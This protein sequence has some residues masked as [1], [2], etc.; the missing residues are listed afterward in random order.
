MR[1]GLPVRT[2]NLQKTFNYSKEY[3]IMKKKFDC[4]TCHSMLHEI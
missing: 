1:Q 4:W 2:D 3:G